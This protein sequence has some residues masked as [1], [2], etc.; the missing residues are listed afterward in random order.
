MSVK[1]IIQGLRRSGTTIFWQTFR[2]DPRL[3]CYD[4]PFN[5]YLFTL[6]ER[7]VL[8]HHEEFARLVEREGWK[9]W[10]K[11]TPIHFTDE[12]RDGLSDSQRDY[13]HYL[14]A[15][16]ER[17]AFDTTR[18]HF[19]IAD[20]HQAAPEAV[21]VHLYRPPESH[22]SSHLLPSA[23]GA[24]GRWRKSVQRRGFWTRP[25]DYNGWSFESI[26]GRSTSSLFAHRLEQV[27]LDPQEVYAMPA[28]GKLLAYWR[29]AFEQ[30]EKVGRDRFGERFVSQSFDAFC[31]EPRRA[32][33]RIYGHMGLAMPDLDF[34]RVH[35]PNA[36]HEADSPLW[37]EYRER[38]GLP[39]L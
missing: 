11:F 28:V 18:C 14:G 23:P 4:E 12:L 7:G 2:Q 31:A 27:G 24:R 22:A 21:L 25:G 39:E 30:V 38:L 37:K 5:Q 35:P 3:T 10:H 1:L 16:G 20:L 8:K 9:F 34:E 29:V 33:E 26:I 36:A 19:K 6:P 15:T 17:V 13:L 32:V